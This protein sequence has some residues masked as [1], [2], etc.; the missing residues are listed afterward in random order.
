MDG[1]R[2]PTA[3]LDER[4]ELVALVGTGGAAEVWRAHDRRLARDVAVKIL[5]GPAARDASHRKRIER[6]ARALAAVSHTNVVAVYDYGEQ[7]T[8]GGEPVP[9]IVMELVDG[10]DLARHLRTTGPLDPDAAV[11]IMTGVLAGIAQAHELGIVHGDIK[12]ANIFLAP[13]GPKVGDFGVA[14]ILSEETGTT[15]VATTPTYAAPEV[16]RGEKPTYASDIYSAGCI[17][18]ETLCGRPPFTGQT[19][20]DVSR[21]HTEDA[22]PRP[23]TIRSGVPPALE[24]SILQALAKD[25]ADRPAAAADLAHRMSD[26]RSTV[27]PTS[28]VVPAGVQTGSPGTDRD[29]E[30][31]IHDDPTVRVVANPTEVLPERPRPRRGTRIGR[32]LL[33][34]PPGLAIAAAAIILL[35]TQAAARVPVPDFVGMPKEAAQELAEQEGLSVDV[36]EVDEGGKA[37]T[38]VR[39]S[40]PSSIRIPTGETVLLTVTLGAP[41]VTVPDVTGYTTADAAASLQEAGLTVAQTAYLVDTGVDPGH[42]VRTEPPAGTEV[43]EGTETTILA[44]ALR[45]EQPGGGGDDDEEIDDRD[46]NPPNGNRGRGRGNRGNGGD[47]D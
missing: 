39:Q 33:R 5:S 16:L 10:P 29:A 36:E 3:V 15:T 4:Y 27:G 9:Y 32:T 42:V 1:P 45:A 21:Q 44:A 6:E 28:G 40:P 25:P 17:A 31:R 22:P 19:F 14:R 43:D 8:R 34:I 12:P 11:A 13:G 30:Q 38:V 23:S 2:E 46:E 20:W 35:M 7:P 47:D 18:F 41:Q 37:G 26:V 24:G